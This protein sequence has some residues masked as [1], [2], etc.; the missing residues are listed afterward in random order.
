MQQHLSTVKYI[1]KELDKGLNVCMFLA[2][3][4]SDVYRK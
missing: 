4:G 3:V 2:F 1:V